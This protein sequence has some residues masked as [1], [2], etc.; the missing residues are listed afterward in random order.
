MQSATKRRAA[1]A[2]RSTRSNAVVL[3]DNNGNIIDLNKISVVA[4]NGESTIRLGAFDGGSSAPAGPSQ[5]SATTNLIAPGSLHGRSGTAAIKDGDGNLT[6]SPKAA[7]E[8][9]VPNR[10]SLG[11]TGD[12]RSES[13]KSGPV[14]QAAS[15]KAFS[16]PPLGGTG[17]DPE[18]GTQNARDRAVEVARGGPRESGPTAST[19]A[20]STP[21]TAAPAHPLSYNAPPIPPAPS[22]PVSPFP[23]PNPRHK[24][25]PHHHPPTACAHQTCHFINKP[26]Q[27]QHCSFGVCPLCRDINT[28]V[29]Q[30]E[31]SLYTRW[32][33]DVR[34]R[35]AVHKRVVD[36]F[37]AR[38]AEELSRL[39]AAA[40]QF[41]PVGDLGGPYAAE[42]TTN[43]DGRNDGTE[44]TAEA[45][46][47]DNELL[48]LERSHEQAIEEL[49]TQ[50]QHSITQLNAS[51][52]ETVSQLQAQHQHALSAVEK[53]SQNHLT[54]TH[55]IYTQ[56]I[57]D[58]KLQ[59]E[60]DIAN[61][62]THY[63]K[64]IE[65][66]KAQH[67]EEISHLNARIADLTESLAAAKPAK[68][69]KS[70]KDIQLDELREKVAQTRQATA[71]EAAELQKER[72]DL[73]KLKAAIT[74]A[75]P[76]PAFKVTVKPDKKGKDKRRQN[77]GAGK[78]PA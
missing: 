38:H 19:A 29:Q 65:Q 67:D 63:A 3:K 34:D 49:K 52:A 27:L 74:A 33:R 4:G 59:S 42:Q 16:T 61:L 2:L 68:P 48:E 50:H 1:A 6:A 64:E 55:D 23:P 14:P 20:S 17:S 22:N 37:H 26:G 46:D 9:A 8:V 53:Q 72:E 73:S 28:L 13:R 11:G 25:P 31:S 24:A 40:A 43:L 62:H 5:E 70:A 66:L 76:P 75:S 15:T 60:E 12:R 78:E 77:E 54:T 57:W 47:K 45:G 58:Q 32:E 30:V 18:T 35:E 69:G 71:K 56:S 36:A 21:P 44:K 41:K 39:R 10:G 51:H 7:A